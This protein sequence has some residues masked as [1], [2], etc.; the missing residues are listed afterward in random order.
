MEETGKEVIKMEVEKLGGYCSSPARNVGDLDSMIALEMW[1]LNEYGNYFERKATVIA[2]G[3]EMGLWGKKS[4][5]GKMVLRFLQ[6]NEVNV[7]ICDIEKQWEVEE[8]EAKL[9]LRC[10]FAIWVK[11]L[12]T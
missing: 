12:D 1:D 7:A 6:S 11:I 4:N 3:L 8:K 9:S 2:E 5:E 10:L